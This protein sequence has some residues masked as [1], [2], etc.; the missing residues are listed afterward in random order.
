MTTATEQPTTNGSMPYGDIE[1]N[2][3]QISVAV[4]R[5]EYA[6]RTA[7]DA[8]ELDGLVYNRG[9]QKRAYLGAKLS[10]MDA[11]KERM[12]EIS[13]IARQR[14]HNTDA[15]DK[16]LDALSRGLR[17]LAERCDQIGA[18][19]ADAVDAMLAAGGFEFD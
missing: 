18:E 3:A 19:G 5:S 16:K 10:N 6:I 15:L 17:F 1:V 4:G 14:T 2:L 7:W 12:H 13:R 9:H 11:I 8:G